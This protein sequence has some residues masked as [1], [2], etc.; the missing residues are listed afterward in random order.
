MPATFPTL[1][2]DETVYSGW[3]R[4]GDRVGETS[5]YLLSPALFN[6][7]CRDT[8]FNL[9]PRIHAFSKT[10]DGEQQYGKPNYLIQHHTLYPLYSLNNNPDKEPSSYKFRECFLSRNH[11]MLLI[12]HQY[13]L[14]P[15][16][17]RFC[18]QCHI[19]DINN[20]G[21]PYWHRLHQ[22][23]GIQICARHLCFLEDSALII[24]MKNNISLGHFISA[25]KAITQTTDFRVLDGVDT[26]IARLQILFA[27]N[28]DFMLNHP[29]EYIDI[30][31]LL[32]ISGH[33]FQMGNPRY[34]FHLPRAITEAIEN[35]Y[36][37]EVRETLGIRIDSKTL[38]GMV[39]QSHPS[40]PELVFLLLDYLGIKIES[41]FNFSSY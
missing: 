5:L 40:A 11:A 4:F 3:A 37:H 33:K 22:V 14:L 21:E 29:D 35:K 2:P 26:E 30:V 6:E 17:A 36:S 27:K 24:R 31:G 19:E 38:T 28:A 41:A 23:P 34:P 18:P 20:Y 13:S 16:H 9:E 8:R 10:F 15:T 12:R 32:N 39:D 7:R 1:L 25:R